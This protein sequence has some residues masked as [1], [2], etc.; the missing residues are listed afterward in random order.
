VL[1][2]AP[3]LQTLLGHPDWRETARAGGP[4]PVG[5][6]DVE[7]RAPLTRPGKVVCVGLNFAAHI[8]EMGRDLPDFPTLFAKYADALV[9]PGDD[10]ELP[11][12]SASM[13]WEGE[14]A[15]V[16]GSTVRRADRAA[17]EAAIAGYTILNDVTARDYQYR[18]TQWLQGKT[19]ERT[20][21][22]GP[23]VVTPDEFDF[24][25]VLTTEVDGQVM[26]QSALSDL[27]F[28]PVAL[29]EY[30][31]T[32]VSLHPGDIV[33]T[34]TPHGVGHAR[35]PQIYLEDGS[36]LVTRIDGIGELRNVCRR[37]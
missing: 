14:L 17:A 2:P 36:V 1:L 18:T 26:Q 15:V 29:I 10:I 35:S 27:V 24:D 6:D 9:G 21:P 12:E 22:V 37:D 5:L 7:F 31:S 28:G 8:T 32:I 16:I 23:V 20:T 19:F 34:G 13:D 11:P 25:A 4:S 33:A 30:I 3:D